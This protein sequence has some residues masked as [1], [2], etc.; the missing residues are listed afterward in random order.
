LAEMFD[1]VFAILVFEFGVVET[2]PGGVFL[3]FV[4]NRFPIAV[5]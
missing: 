5:G 2:G 4:A 1:H 3:I